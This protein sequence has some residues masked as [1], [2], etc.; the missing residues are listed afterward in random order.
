M[1]SVVLSDV[2][3][4]PDI[5]RGG[6]FVDAALPA[7]GSGFAALDAELPGRGWPRGALTELLCDGIGLGEVS[8]LQPALKQLCANDG[9]LVLI[10]PPHGL[11]ASAWRAAGIP[12]ERLL[13]VNAVSGRQGTR[14]VLWAAEQAF[15]SDAPAA[16]V[17]WS[18]MANARAVHR[19]QLAAT[20]SHAAGF[21]F[22][23]S[24]AASD[25]SAAPLRL[26]LGNANNMLGIRILKRRGP[27]AT[28]AL[29]L[30]VSRPAPWRTHV[31]HDADALARPLPAATAARRLPASVNE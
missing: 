29:H 13:I 30:A 28:Q 12:L 15:N 11:Q 14:D 6:C 25:S 7:I 8:L 27:P 2:L 31:K 4:R 3:A 1:E 19:L 23:P 10:A 22:R 17:C 5:R 21:L 20:A 9:W 26:Q 24:R 16:V 18:S